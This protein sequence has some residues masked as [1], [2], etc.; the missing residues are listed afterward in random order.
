[1][2]FN[3]EFTNTLVKIGEKWEMGPKGVNIK[4]KDE[5]GH[6]LTKSHFIYLNVRKYQGK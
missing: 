4:I 2:T 5:R 6:I 3:N 1:M